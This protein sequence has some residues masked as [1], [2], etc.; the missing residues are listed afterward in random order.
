MVALLTSNA[1]SIFG[2]MTNFWGPVVLLLLF[3]LSATI[4]GSLVLGRPIYL[5]LNGSKPD[6]IRLL[7]YTIGWL[8]V[9]IV[10]VLLIQLMF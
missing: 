3:V 7:F 1:E 9:I 4:V 6:A 10:I 8:F 2:K 5:Y